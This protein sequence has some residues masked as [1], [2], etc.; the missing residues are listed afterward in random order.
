MGSKWLMG[1]LAGLLLTTHAFAATIEQPLPNPAQ[2]AQARTLFHALKCVVCEGQS[3][4]ES[5]AAL[6]A[7]MRARI[8]AMVA[9]G[10]SE[11]EIL[12][13]FRASYGDRILLTPPLQA[14]TYLL[15]LAP[16]FLLT[17]GGIIL[18]RVTRRPSSGEPS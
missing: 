8:R 18:W 3:L 11:A 5:D 1:A 2:E 6:A 15:W 17:I 7:Q 12:A 13:F 14:D 16:L 4:A 10:K 9:E